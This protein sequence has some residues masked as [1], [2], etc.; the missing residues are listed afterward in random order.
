MLRISLIC[1]VVHVSYIVVTFMTQ[2]LHNLVEA[3]FGL[4]KYPV[5]R[6]T[7]LTAMADFCCY[8]GTGPVKLTYLF[9]THFLLEKYNMQG[10][11]C[12]S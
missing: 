2:L 9:V 8:K 3:S 4:L 5:E 7:D 12:P 1:M 6:A 11:R 10:G